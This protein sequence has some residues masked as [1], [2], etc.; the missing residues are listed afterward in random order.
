MGIFEMLAHNMLHT[1]EG[2]KVFLEKK[3]YDLWQLLIWSNAL[4]RSNNTDYNWRTNLFSE[5]P[6]N[7]C[8]IWTI[9]FFSM[10]KI[11]FFLR[12]WHKILIF[13]LIIQ[14]RGIKYNMYYIT[15]HNAM[16]I[17]VLAIVIFSF[18]IFII[19][20][21]YSCNFLSGF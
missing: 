6:S 5:I 2:K 16:G 4:N 7:I 19:V 18:H 8:Y 15:Q 21:P 11:D 9:Q 13:S 3:K 17:K 10:F 1:H 14:R 20:L 12:F